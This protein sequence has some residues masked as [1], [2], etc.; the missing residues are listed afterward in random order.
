MQSLLTVKC[1]FFFRATRTDGIPPREGRGIIFPSLTSITVDFFTFYELLAPDSL[2]RKL[3]LARLSAVEA[4]ISRPTEARYF[5]RASDEARLLPRTDLGRDVSEIF[6]LFFAGIN[7]QNDEEMRRLCFVET[8]ES[9][10]ADTTL[11]KI[12]AHL[13]NT[14]HAIETERGRALQNEIEAVIASKESEVCP[15]CRQ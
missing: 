9:R 3:H 5:V 7:S 13:T 2:V 1:E 12:A 8:R 10:D 6:N 4:L 15:D 14:I 11:L